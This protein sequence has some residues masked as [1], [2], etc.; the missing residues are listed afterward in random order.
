M[1]MEV[2][3]PNRFRTP[4]KGEDLSGVLKKGEAVAGRVEEVRTDGTAKIT[5]FGREYEVTLPA[6]YQKGDVVRFV[7][8]ETDGRL[9]L[10]IKPN[11]PQTATQTANAAATIAEVLGD[12]N[13]QDTPE[14]RSAFAAL[15]R[16]GIPV[17]AENVAVLAR[18]V[19]QS[20]LSGEPAYQ[21]AAFV[22]KSG[23][24][25]EPAFVRGAAMLLADS[26]ELVRAADRIYNAVASVQPPPGAEPV[27]QE[28]VAQL[29]TLFVAK[30]GAAIAESQRTGF[31][32]QILSAMNRIEEIGRA[33]AA[34]K[35]DLVMLNT[36]ISAIDSGVEQQK[37]GTI[38]AAKHAA[39]LIQRL[40]SS[41]PNDIQA[42]RYILQH[43]AKGD[44][45]QL[46]GLLTAM[47]KSFVQSDKG[48]A[49]LG[50]AHREL[51][52]LLE[53][54]AVLKAANAATAAV[55]QDFSYAEAIYPAVVQGQVVRV[56]FQ[57]RRRGKMRLRGEKVGVRLDVETAGL[58]RVIAD[59]AA[60]EKRVK[61]DFA[62]EESD[63][64]TL[65]EKHSG[66][67]KDKITELGY[68][69][70]VRVNKVRECAG[71]FCEDLAAGKDDIRIIDV[72]V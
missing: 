36:I 41:A 17:T 12:L 16:S 20:G 58:G 37:D 11:L 56:K 48:L 50:E 54:S 67:L 47:E 21:A 15:V 8:R 52:G 40:L 2:A 25:L 46:R 5:L 10:E 23:L 3:F 34:S 35:S 66:E 28:L 4:L 32:A 6:G 60:A 7:V 39:D 70:E 71:L 65:L 55:A 42:A 49:Q 69:A 9:V 31:A 64:A 45:E 72:K 51:S 24:P 61:I 62:V 30:D 18:A 43:T 27:L 26:T 1:D 13:I 59:L 29:K 22:L 33:I 19:I 63:A 38:Y 68:A 57:H 44:M 14:S 53:R